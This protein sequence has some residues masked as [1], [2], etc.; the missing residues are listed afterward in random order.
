V[1]A[2]VRACVRALASVR[3]WALK[4]DRDNDIIIRGRGGNS[5][6]F[7]FN[8]TQRLERICS[9]CEIMGSTIRAMNRQ[10]IPY[11]GCHV[12][13]KGRSPKLTSVVCG[14]FSRQACYC[15]KDRTHGYSLWTTVSSASVPRTM[16]RCGGISEIGIHR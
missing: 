6:L 11:S 10:R 15:W 13:A 16:T 2:C 7:R 1:R 8:W 4:G 9:K 14:T 5:A 3:A 12:T